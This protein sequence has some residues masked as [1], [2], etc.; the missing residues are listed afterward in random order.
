MT[1]N[2]SDDQIPFAQLKVC[3]NLT[4]SLARICG[5]WR[6]AVDTVILQSYSASVSAT[7]N[8][9]S[10]DTGSSTAWWDVGCVSLATWKTRATLL[11]FLPSK[12]QRP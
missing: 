8:I 12:M 3:L 5:P 1:S 7:V 4:L 9:P 6:V 10:H 11:P 2:L